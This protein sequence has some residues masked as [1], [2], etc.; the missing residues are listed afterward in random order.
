M[1]CYERLALEDLA[2]NASELSVRFPN[3]EEFKKNSADA[4]TAL[5]LHL[6]S[7]PDCQKIEALRKAS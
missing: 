7:C 1:I 5:T 3:G 4:E 2:Q 6:I